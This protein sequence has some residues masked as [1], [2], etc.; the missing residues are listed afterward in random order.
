M[1]GVATLLRELTASG[2][3]VV[4]VPSGHCVLIDVGR[5]ER[6]VGDDDP[7]QSCLA[8]I[9]RE[10][11]VRAAPHLAG[12]EGGGP[13][14]CI[15]LAVPT[16]LGSEETH[17]V[18][19][20]LAA[21]FAG[22]DAL[23]PRQSTAHHGNGNLELLREHVPGVEH[24]LVRTPDGDYEVFG[25]GAGPALVMLHPFNIGA[26]VFGP[27]FADL[28]DGYRV[29]TIHNPGVGATTAATDL[30]PDGIARLHRRVLD[31]LHVDWPVHLA[32]ASFGGLIA[33]T[34]ALEHPED[35]ASLVLI[36]SSYKIGNRVGEISRLETVAREDME[37]VIAESGD[38]WLAA[39]RGALLETLLRAESMDPRIGLRYVD[40]FGHRPDL[41]ARLPQV[42][43]PTLILQGRHDTIIP[44][45]TAHLLHGAIPDAR[46]REIEDA[47]HFPTLTS[48]DA[49]NRLIR[50]FL[51]ATSVA[52]TGR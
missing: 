21:L 44:K 23:P 19:A 10:T 2:V 40:A 32:G 15:R 12:G 47:G 18:A 45:K 46:Y 31:D 33:L 28:A 51:A 42:S 29:L 38:G 26:G 17:D 50:E 3:P 20:R 8:L 52:R 4:E 25:A 9:E 37:H 5:V 14:R 41:M 24:R 36:G 6:L 30:T 48:P 22:E 1:D 7:V 27:Q 39:R 13:D 35:T 34:F 11:G 49:V 16:G 43:A